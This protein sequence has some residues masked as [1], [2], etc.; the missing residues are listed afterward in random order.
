MAKKE[1]IKNLADVEHTASCMNVIDQPYTLKI[2]FH[3]NENLKT[4]TFKHFY[5]VFK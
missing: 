2:E 3:A 1:E 4:R 5:S